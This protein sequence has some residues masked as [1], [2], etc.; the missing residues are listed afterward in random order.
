M[1][2]QNVKNG[3]ENKSFRGRRLGT[4]LHDEKIKLTKKQANYYRCVAGMLEGKTSWL[5]KNNTENVDS[6]NLC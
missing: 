4:V 3:G 6:H 2:Q 5:I 1:W